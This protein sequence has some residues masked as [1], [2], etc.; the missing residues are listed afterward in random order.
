MVRISK[1]AFMQWEMCPQAYKYGYIDKLPF[2]P[3]IPMLIGSA[4][5]DYADDLF[6]AVDF[7]RLMAAEEKQ[8]IRRVFFETSA[9][10]KVGPAIAK[11]VM[12][13]IR[14]ET[15]RLHAIKV[16]HPDNPEDHYVPLMLER[17]LVVLNAYPDIDMVG[18]VD[19]LDPIGDNK[20]AMVEYKSG[21]LNQYRVEKELLFYVILLEKS[22]ELNGTDF[23]EVTHLVGYSPYDNANFI[24]QVSQRRKVNVEKKLQKMAEDILR[25]SF[26]RK[27]NPFCTGCRGM[28]PCLDSEVERQEIFELLMTAAHTVQEMTEV[29]DASPHVIKAILSDLELEGLVS[30][31]KKGRRTYW[32][33]E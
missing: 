3:N 1:S 26:I 15:D 17:K 20:A 2:K 33:I 5:H 12:N 8:D 24:S 14:F 13:F 25:K 31:I 21:G 28:I 27:E 16:A 22:N 11:R 32:W 10:I 30:N 19:R 18:I 6:G 4:F 7:E 29:L 9:K 23:P